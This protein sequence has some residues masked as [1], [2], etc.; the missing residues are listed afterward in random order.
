[1]RYIL[2]F[3]LFDRN[4]IV[5]P[6]LEM[7][8]WSWNRVLSEISINRVIQVRLIWMIIKT[9]TIWNECYLLPHCRFEMERHKIHQFRVIRGKW[10]VRWF[11]KEGVDCRLFSTLQMYKQCPKGAEVTTVPPWVYPGL[12]RVLTLH[13]S[14]WPVDGQCEIRAL[15]FLR[16]LSNTLFQMNHASPRTFPLVP[17]SCF[18]FSIFVPLKLFSHKAVT[19]HF[20]AFLEAPW[21]HSY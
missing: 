2:C 14:R 17:L 15:H 11:E 21:R 19:K 13:S 1:M 5:V 18:L 7:H 8:V 16:F 9:V 6:F 3:I 4:L 10:S 12:I 20:T